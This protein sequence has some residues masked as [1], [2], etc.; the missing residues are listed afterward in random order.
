VAEKD[1]LSNRQIGKNPASKSQNMPKATL[2]EPKKIL[3][4]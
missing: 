1:C 4:L 2:D 3:N